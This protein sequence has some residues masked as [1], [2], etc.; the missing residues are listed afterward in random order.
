VAP[1]PSAAAAGNTVNFDAVD[2]NYTLPDSIPAGPVTLVMRNAGKEAHTGVT[3]Q[4]FTAALQQGEGPALALVSFKGG[5]GALDPGSNTESVSVNLQPGDYVVL[6]FL[7]GADGIPHFAKGMIKPLTV[8]AGTT[9]TSATKPN[10]PV[11]ITLK[12]FAFDSPDTLPSGSN[13]W[14]ITNNGP[15]PHELQVAKLASGGSANDI[16]N[17]FSTPTPSGPPTFQS[18]GGF[19][20]I[21][22]NSGGTLTLNLPAGQYAFYC[23]IPDPTNGKRHLQEGMLKQVTIS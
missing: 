9:P 5:T 8:T 23:A 3:F 21:D 11:T 10:A 6:C 14:A 16:L 2:F 7:T 12:D 20:G 1:S 22:P 18:V 13:A 19:Q 17:F 15:Q 4:Q